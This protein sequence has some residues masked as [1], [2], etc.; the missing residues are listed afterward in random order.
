[1]FF[2]FFVIGCSGGWL[3]VFKISINGMVIIGCKWDFV[4]C[5]VVGDDIRILFNEKI[6]FILI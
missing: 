3:I 5:L 1:M 4:D 6:Y 2:F